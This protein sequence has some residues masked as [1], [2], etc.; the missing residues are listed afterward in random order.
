MFIFVLRKLESGFQENSLSNF[1]LVLTWFC[2]SGTFFLSHAVS[3]SFGGVSKLRWL[4]YNSFPIGL[5]KIRNVLKQVLV[6]ISES[7]KLG[8]HYL[9]NSSWTSLCNCGKSV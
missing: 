5:G 7:L 4:D 6:V 9:N 8:I 2:Y 3:L 1:N